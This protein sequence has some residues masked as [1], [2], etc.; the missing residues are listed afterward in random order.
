MDEHYIKF[1]LNYHMTFAIVFCTS[2]ECHMIKSHK[3]W[4][5]VCL[6]FEGEICKPFELDIYNLM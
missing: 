5:E 1:Y 4:F 6:D 2:F 3:G